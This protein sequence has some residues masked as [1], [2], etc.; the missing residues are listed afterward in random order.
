MEIE[1]TLKQATAIKKINGYSSAI[2][3]LIASYDKIKPIDLPRLLDKIYTYFNHDLNNQTLKEFIAELVNTKTIE[4]Y[5]GL[6]SS[7]YWI[8]QDFESYKQTIIFQTSKLTLTKPWHYCYDLKLLQKSLCNYYNAMGLDDFHN[9]SEYIYNLISSTFFDVASELMMFDYNFTRFYFHLRQGKE[10]K[11][12]HPDRLIPLNESVE[13]WFDCDTDN[14]CRCLKTLNCKVPKEQIIKI[15]KDKIFYHF[16]KQLGFKID[17][18]N[19]DYNDTSTFSL[20]F[21]NKNDYI[22]FDVLNE[23]INDWKNK[24]ATNTVGIA[25]AE[26]NDILQ[27]IIR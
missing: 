22:D 24:M 17:I 27:R 4:Q 3:F 26:T 6:L 7:Y 20:S 9:A 15:I 12:Y 23:K 8:L 16:P 18:L 13:G 1:Q 21:F 10:L 14:D 19:K 25:I 2:D 11:Y 5:S